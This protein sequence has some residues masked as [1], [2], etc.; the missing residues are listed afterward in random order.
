ML[1]IPIACAVKN[2]EPLP[3]LLRTKLDELEV[4]L[5]VFPA[6]DAIFCCRGDDIKV[7]SYATQ[8]FRQL[9]L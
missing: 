1:H 7:T 9:Q 5:E 4:A 6:D 3:S 8:Y 2:P